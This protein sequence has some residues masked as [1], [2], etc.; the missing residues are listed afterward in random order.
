[1]LAS[2]R[3]RY[4]PLTIDRLDRFHSLVQD[5]HIRQYLL[6][7]EVFPREWS[8][9]RVR[10]SEALVA[11]R[12]VGLW[13]VSERV[14]G[15]LAG[16]CGFLEIPSVHA[17]PQL[18]YALVEQFTGKGYATEMARAMIDDARASGGFDEIIAVVDGVNAASVRVL[19]KLGCERAAT[20]QGAFG[21]MFTFRLR[22]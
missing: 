16:F 15:A 5:A 17:E 7:G 19:E 21:D 22:L 14:S 2:P 1:M 3:L 10:E 6:D 9:A 8:E 18:V 4:E 13:L 11:R 20:H 12:G